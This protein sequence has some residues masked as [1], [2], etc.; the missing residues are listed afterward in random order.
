M[1]GKPG[2][3]GVKFLK[4]YNQCKGFAPDL[5]P[6]EVGMLVGELVNGNVIG[7]SMSYQILRT[8]NVSKV[9]EFIRSLTK[10]RDRYI[11][12][13]AIERPKEQNGGDS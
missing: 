8:C 9:D 13:L 5:S 12:D 7:D 11:D 4:L 2:R 1:A 3:T 6:T 10:I